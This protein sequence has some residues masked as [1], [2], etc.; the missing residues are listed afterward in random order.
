MIEEFQLVGRELFLAGLNNSHS[1]NFSIRLGDK[2]IITRRGSMLGN[3]T[4]EDLIEVHLWEE[5]SSLIYAS[6][7]V[8]VHRSIYRNTPALSI[9]HAHPPYAVALS[10]FYDTIEPIDA[11]GKYF[12]PRIPVITTK[13]T[14][15]AM[16]VARI[17]P[18]WLSK[19]RIVVLREHGSFAIGDFLEEAFQLTTSLEHSCKILYFNKMFSPF[20]E[21][22]RK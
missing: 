16:E 17:L 11:E 7:E 20:K 1:G 18:Y 2:L 13:E 8:E 9:V 10:F 21:V 14:I 22:N 12:L 6:T 4:A 3:L 15:G 19:Y 5:D